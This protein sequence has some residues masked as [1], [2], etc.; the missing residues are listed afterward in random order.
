MT[1][2]KHRLTT[3][4][5]GLL[6]L[7]V[8]AFAQNQEMSP[9]LMEAIGSN[10]DSIPVSREECI[11]IALSQSPTIRIADLEVKR[12]NFAK[13]E[14]IGNLLPQIG[15]SLSYQRS[16]E[17]QTIRMNMGGQSQKLKMGSDNT[18]NTGFSV[19]LPVI[20]PALWKAISISDTQIAQNLESARSSRLELVNQVNKAYYALML[21]IASKDVIK[22]NYDIAKYTAEIYKKQFE[23]GT[24]SEYDVLRSEVQVKNIEPS[25]LDADISVKQCQLSLNVLMGIDDALNLYPTVTMEDMQKD[26]YAYM[27]ESKSLSGNSS[28][29]SLELQQKMAAENVTMK[30]FA[31][32]PTLGA[33]FNL[34]WL[35]LSNGPMFRDVEFSPY[36]SV[37][38]SLSVPVFSGGAKWYQMKQ[39][40]VQEKE[41]AFQKENL[42]NSLKMQVDLALDNIN[43]QAK[44]IDSSKEGVRQAKKAH[45]IML[46][47]F[48]I[49]AASYLQLRD[50]ELADTSA[51]LSY[52]Q[53][54]YNYLVST[55][56]LDLLLGKDSAIVKAN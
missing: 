4:L 54:I 48:Q 16:I 25:L 51:R 14:T 42:V 41:L 38:I 23:Q 24:A 56:E 46:K 3:L 27:L 50:S 43:R 19:S 30:K 21:A 18:W 2:R 53:A 33:S 6:C 5:T 55:S 17:L 11:D 32:I 35:S 52:L 15:F 22:Q 10:A 47:S 40:Q 31:W 37:G 26:M 29:R 39:A 28:L 8:Q 36:S 9:L 7:G 12:V 1:I 45:E 20:A 13:R 49:G 44:Q 34:N